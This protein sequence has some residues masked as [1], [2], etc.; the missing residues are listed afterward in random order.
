MGIDYK[1]LRKTLIVNLFAGPGAGKSTTAAGLY[2]KMK[3]AGYDCELVREFAKDVVWEQNPTALK[4]QLYV[5]GTQSYRQTILFD[6]VEVIIT[7]SPLLLGVIYFSHENK[8]I[9][10]T[11]KKLITELFKDQHNLN[12][13]V[14]RKKDFNP[15]G[16]N[17]NLEQS[18]EIDNQIENLLSKNDLW[19]SDVEGTPAGVYQLFESVTTYLNK[20][21]TLKG[22]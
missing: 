7:D 10:E 5:T 19:F 20:I 4:D 22:G 1:R 2:S 15:N 21:H 8:V 17:H 3:N 13:I 11:Y 14:R 18:I 12:F 9:E 16:R 6:K